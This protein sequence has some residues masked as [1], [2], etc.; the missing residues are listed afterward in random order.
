MRLTKFNKIALVKF[1][2]NISTIVVDIIIIFDS[3]FFFFYFIMISYLSPSPFDKHFA[4]AIKQSQ[5][6]KEN[7]A[8]FL[9]LYS[10]L[11]DIFIIAFLRKFFLFFFFI[12]IFSNIYKTLRTFF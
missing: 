1:L 8:L 6:C 12:Y 3:F 2:A 10:I 11:T 5:D 9:F 7:W 4:I